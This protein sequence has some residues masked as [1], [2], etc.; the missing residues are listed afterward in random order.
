MNSL[1]PHDFCTVKYETLDDVVSLVSKFGCGCLIAK[2]DVEDAFRIIP[3]SPFDY[4]LLGFKFNGKI[5]YD[6]DLPM[7]CSTSCQTFEKFSQ[8]IQWILLERFKMCGMSHILDDFICIG[9]PN[10]ELCSYA[11]KAFMNL[12]EDVKDSKT[13]RH[14]L[15]FTVSK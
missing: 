1:I 6:K 12:A 3:V 13:V 2:A 8:S 11:L 14:V 4:H 10:F 7:G 5:F 15:L 9:P